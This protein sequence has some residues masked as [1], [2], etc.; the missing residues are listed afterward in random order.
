ML[1][2]EIAHEGSQLSKLT[3]QDASSSCACHVATSNARAPFASFA[4]WKYRR[5]VEREQ[6]P[7]FVIEGGR[8]HDFL[9]ISTAVITAFVG[10]APGAA[11]P[12]PSPK[13][14]STAENRQYCKSRARR[15]VIFELFEGRFANLKPQ[16]STFAKKWPHPSNT[17]QN[18]KHRIC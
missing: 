15:S 2:D 6:E 13:P 18:C 8:Y 10:M 9:G 17:H 1:H 3:A 11:P 4:H 5:A 16:T 14:R 7:T 12:N